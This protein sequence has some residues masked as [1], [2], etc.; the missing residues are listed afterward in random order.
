MKALGVGLG[1]V[2]LPGRRG[3]AGRRARRRCVV[4]AGRRRWPP[5]AACTDLAPHRSPTPTAG[6]RLRHRRVATATRRGSRFGRAADRHAGRD[7]GDRRR[8][9][10]AGRVLIE[11]AGAGCRPSC[12]R[13]PRRHLRPPGRRRRRQGQQRRRRPR[14][15]RAARGAGC[16]GPR[17]RRRRRAA[18]PHRLRPG[19][20]RRL[21]HRLPRH[22]RAARGRV[23]PPC[24]PSTSRPGSTGSPARWAVARSAA[25]LTVTF[26][27]LKPGLLFGEGRR[28]AGEIDVA[29]IG[30][31]AR[32]ARALLV[33]EDD[34]RG[35]LPPRPARPQVVSGVPGRRRVTRDERGG[36]A[37]RRGPPSAPAPASAD[38][39]PGATARDP[40]PIEA[41]AAR[42]RRPAGPTWCSTRSSGS[43]R[44]WSARAWQPTRPRQPRPA[45]L[46]GRLD[47]PAVVD[48]TALTA[49]AGHPDVTRG[50][51]APTVLTPHDGEFGR[52]MGSAPGADRIDAARALAAEYGATV[53]LKGPTTV[54][55]G[56]DGIAPRDRRRRRS[57]GDGGH[58]RRPERRDRR[59][60]RPRRL[61]PRA[62]AAAAF[63][64]GRAAHLGPGRGLIASDLVDL[65]ADVR[66]DLDD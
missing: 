53:L 22:L 16:T 65:I 49:L 54:V 63:V 39:H 27:A 31:D 47:I 4:T 26:A 48:G 11:R 55:A 9:A 37:G 62:A 1:A 51:R 18:S 59:P 52:L 57:A 64:H 38:G 56:P 46:I 23:R 2:A 44:S 58:R 34:A 32:S 13:P 33:E 6:H 8:R 3:G 12:G 7:G 60:P 5:S 15:G 21:R 17:L 24:S 35:W 19:D 40:M 66:T 25:D 20:R 43:R 50:R 30:L 29:D 10:R 41:V 61:R 14:R 28:L 45:Q 36:M 42:S